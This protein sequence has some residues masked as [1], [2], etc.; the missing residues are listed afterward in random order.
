M[1]TSPSK[2]ALNTQILEQA[3]EWLVEFE[4]GDADPQTQQHFDSWLRQS[5]E[6][7][8]A[9]LE[10]LPIWKHGATAQFARDAGPEALI[11]YARSED[12]VVALAGEPAARTASAL[13]R[14]RT[15][16]RVWLAAAAAAA[17]LF[18]AVALLWPA[19]RGPVYVTGT[20]EQHSVS[21]PDGSTLLL[22][23]RSKVRVRFTE[24]LRRL[25]LLE[26]QALFSVATDATRPFVVFAG[27]TQVR[28][29]GTEFDVYRKTSG[30][31][32]TV[33]EGRVA[34]SA[35]RES[36]ALVAAGEQL[37]VAASERRA[38][39]KPQRANLTVVTAWTQ[40]RL[41]FDDSTLA[42]VVEEF[43]R[44]NTRRLVLKDATL[45]AFPISG[46]FSS[47][48]PASLVRFLEAQPGIG[49]VVASNEIQIF[50]RR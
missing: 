36:A 16:P 4:A 30:T 31:V 49:V 25:E 32:V 2:A 50:A 28:A 39:A 38:S 40:R 47:T 46:A 27:G 33:V 35:P 1:S 24:R 21:L 34:V 22:N 13:P 19:I 41:V 15:A 12:K 23:A 45:S 48:N 44:Y 5:P 37:T 6:H 26:G 10:L 11:A 7:V 17:V 29:V 8:R 14:R 9:Y 20:G 18:V 43:N 3:S 42:E